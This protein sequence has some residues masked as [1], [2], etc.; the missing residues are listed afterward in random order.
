MSLT[1]PP[2]IG[3]HIPSTTQSHQHSV[4]Q[5]GQDA[6]SKYLLLPTHGPQHSISPSDQ[7]D[8]HSYNTT[9]FTQLP[10]YAQESTPSHSSHSQ[11][12]TPSHVSFN[13]G[14]S[15]C[16]RSYSYGSAGHLEPPETIP[17]SRYGYPDADSYPHHHHC[18]YSEEQ[19]GYVPG[20][21]VI[22]PTPNSGET[23]GTPSTE[24]FSVPSP[25]SPGLQHPS[26]FKF[27]AQ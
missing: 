3:H 26:R 7:G 11:E 6:S 15:D 10:S 9:E 14:I 17:L 22:P 19:Y 1:V 24:P 12:S 25:I 13:S 4:A 8:G 2:A 18:Q 5:S 16:P 20:L 23:P 27:S 21:K